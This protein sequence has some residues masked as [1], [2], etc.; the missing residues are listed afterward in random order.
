MSATL[1]STTDPVKNTDGTYQLNISGYTLNA[2]EIYVP[3][4][5]RF[6]TST[7]ETR[8]ATMMQDSTLLAKST[9]SAIGKAAFS[10][11]FDLYIRA[12]AAY[13]L[14][15]TSDSKRF[16][17][18]YDSKTVDPI[19]VAITSMM[20]TQKDYETI[21]DNIVAKES[22]G[23]KISANVEIL[24]A[25][26]AKSTCLTVK[27]DEAL[28][29]DPKITRYGAFFNS[30]ETKMTCES[31]SNTVVIVIVILLIIAGIGGG[32]FWK[33]KSKGSSSGPSGSVPP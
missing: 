7:E 26:L 14:Y 11:L 6:L 29:T 13:V 1:S 12:Y 31:G 15:K 17:V 10:E 25:I 23:E 20:M 4:T 28:M 2:M 18:L 24:A 5:F 3:S 27:I 8:L 16:F 9:Y 21:F 22:K 33:S 32:L 19:K 30:T